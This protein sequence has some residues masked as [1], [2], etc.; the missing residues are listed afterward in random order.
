MYL[1]V[2]KC[3]YIYLHV[4]VIFQSHFTGFQF[5]SSLI[6][7]DSCRNGW[8]T[9]KYC[10]IHWAPK[11]WFPLPCWFTNSCSCHAMR[12]FLSVPTQLCCIQVPWLYVWHVAVWD[13]AWDQGQ[14][15]RGGEGYRSGNTSKVAYQCSFGNRESL[16]EKLQRSKQ[17]E[18]CNVINLV[19]NSHQV[20]C[21]WNIHLRFYANKLPISGH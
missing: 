12:G 11:N 3:L 4:H 18:L 6:P 15:H 7:V 1:F 14:Q 19:V 21:C 8:G 16:M 13:N 9:V 10:K 20:H 17:G 5:Y 2:Y